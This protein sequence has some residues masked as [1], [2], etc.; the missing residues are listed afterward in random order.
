MMYGIN[1]EKLARKLFEKPIAAEV[2]ELGLIVSRHQPFLACNPD[3]VIINCNDFELLEMK[4]PAT[5]EKAKIMDREEQ[6]AYVPYL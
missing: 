1:M 6:T 2:H 4:R 5:C 3:G